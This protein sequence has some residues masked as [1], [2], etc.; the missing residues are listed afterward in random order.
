MR[1]NFGLL[2]VLFATA[3]LI[4][5]AH[6]LTG[7][8]G[9]DLL[10]RATGNQ[11]AFSWLAVRGFFVISGFLVYRSFERSSGV[12]DFLRRRSRRVWP[13]LIALVLL[14]V[15]IVGPLITDHSATRYFSKGATWRY[16]AMPI[17]IV[18]G[19]VPYD[20]PG[21][22]AEVPHPGV[23]NGSLWTIA[24]EVLFYLATTALFVLKRWST[25][26]RATVLVAF[27]SCMVL[28]ASVDGG[29]IELS[30]GLPLTAF[31]WWSIVDMGVFYCA[32]S[33]MAAW[34]GVARAPMKHL[35]VVALVSMALAMWW[36]VYPMAEGVLL[37]LLVISA[38]LA[39]IGSGARPATVDIS[40]G[41]YLWGYPIQQALM[42]AHPWSPFELAALSVPIAWFAGWLSWQAVER[43]FLG[44]RHLDLVRVDSPQP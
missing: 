30:G 7:D 18:L 23:V 2:R 3:V 42:T 16:A 11:A 37:P 44:D 25:A 29:V 12:L 31:T 17:T 8:T 21:V 28:R 14:T 27:V 10:Q 34:P 36:R 9:G 1:N 32:G 41:T 38:A 22:F 20:L 24:Y 13:A 5:H 39:P 15:F 19:Q 26:P 40:Y 35:F 6:V 33:V 43:P 4:T